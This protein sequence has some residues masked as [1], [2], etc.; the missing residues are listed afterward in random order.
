M[1]RD[2]MWVGL[3]DTFILNV[4]LFI[5][6]LNAVCWLESGEGVEIYDFD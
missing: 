4:G 6:H 3:W 1:M 5:N 2:E